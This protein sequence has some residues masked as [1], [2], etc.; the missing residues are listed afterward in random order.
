MFHIG[1]SA[2]RL[3]GDGSY[4]YGVIN[5]IVT[6][7][8][9]NEEEIKYPVVFGFKD[10][11]GRFRLDRFTPSGQGKL[12]GPQTLFPIVGELSHTNNLPLGN[13]KIDPLPDI[14]VQF[15][16]AALARESSVNLA[17]VRAD[18]ALEKYKARFQ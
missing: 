13:D 18:A 4:T 16:C 6:G 7:N 15:M 3:N 8:I 14:W 11:N 2:K 5:T 17:A 1:Q 9:T 12:N 10:L